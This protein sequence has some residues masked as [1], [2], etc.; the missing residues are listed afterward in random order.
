MTKNTCEVFKT[1]GTIGTVYTYSP[2]GKASISGSVTQPIQWSGEYHDTELGLVYYNYRYYNPKH[3]KWVTR[4]KMPVRNLY[5]YSNAPVQE[6]DYLGYS[7]MNEFCK[8]KFIEN[9]NKIKD[10]AERE[11]N[12]IKDDAERELNKI[13]DTAGNYTQ[14]I[15]G[16][17]NDWFQSFDKTSWEMAT[18]M[19]VKW[20]LNNHDRVTHY[21]AGKDKA[22]DYMSKGVAAQSLMENFKNKNKNA[23]KCSDWESYVKN[24]VYFPG[25]HSLASY[26]KFSLHMERFFQAL[27]NGIESFVGTSKGFAEVTHNTDSITVNYRIENTTS[28]TSF[29]LHLVDE[30]EEG[31]FDKGFMASWVQVYHWNETIPC[32]SDCKK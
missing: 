32:I 1:N 27:P 24:D 25:W 29:F 22:A 12:K 26:D 8:S 21:Y 11:L 9:A 4:D 18:I 16:D 7:L 23:K 19:F 5:M 3:G 14:E 10:D 13:K 6:M 17:I 31:Y 2:Y 15:T 30:A 28:T 20:V